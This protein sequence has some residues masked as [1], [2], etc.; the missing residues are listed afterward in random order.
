MII[1]V[2]GT[3]LFTLTDTQ[4]KVLKSEIKSDIF[5]S[6]MKRRLQWVIMHKYEQCFASLKKEWEPKLAD[7]GV[8]SIPTNKD[9][10]AELVFKQ[11]DYK[12]RSARD[13][14]SAE[15]TSSV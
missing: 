12:D 3:P 10:F 9:A 14:E 13:A 6:D 2:D 11:A 4:K 15:A 8:E 7:A 5:E 1:S